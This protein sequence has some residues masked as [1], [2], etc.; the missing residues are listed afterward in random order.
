[1]RV[2]VTICLKPGILNP[3][4]QTIEKALADLGF[5]GVENLQRAKVISFDLAESNPQAAR[6]KAEAMCETLLANMV[7]E[8]YHIALGEG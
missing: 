6:A 8:S 1:M 2:T 7:M 4:A 5:D 3:E